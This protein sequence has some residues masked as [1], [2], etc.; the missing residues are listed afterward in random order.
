MKIF[1]F[2]FLVVIFLSGCKSEKDNLIFDEIV[3]IEYHIA[4]LP[5]GIENLSSGFSSKNVAQNPEEYVSK[6]L[7]ISKPYLIDQINHKVFIP[8]REVKINTDGKINYFQHKSLDSIENGYFKTSL[9]S[10]S[11]MYFNY[12]LDSIKSG[13]IDSVYYK[14]HKDMIY[15]GS[16]CFLSFKKDKKE[17]YSYTYYPDD[18]SKEIKRFIEFLRYFIKRTKSGPI[19]DKSQFDEI[20]KKV[21]NSKLSS[22]PIRITFESNNEYVPSIQ[23]LKRR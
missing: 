16:Y 18:A 14:E 6:E 17:I 12:L 2:L 4:L 9:N 21:F 23:E 13:H 20:N 10:S 19:E 3:F 22:P 1:S 11:I 7:N 8:F 15:D 5:T